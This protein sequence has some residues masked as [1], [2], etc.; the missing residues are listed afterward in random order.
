MGIPLEQIKDPRLR[1]RVEQALRSFEGL[2]GDLK[3]QIPGPPSD[4]PQGVT[5][6]PRPGKRIR[7]ASKP[8]MNKLEE[9]YCREFL[10]DKIHLGYTTIQGV[11]FML[12]RGLWYKPDFVV[13]KPEVKCIEVKGP[14]VFRGGFEN[15]KMAA[16]QYPWIK[17][18]LVWKDPQNGQW[19]EQTVLP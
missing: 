6:P 12:A 13:W 18:I 7:Q 4:Y 17:W 3:R 1:E 15:L 2:K 10:D 11:R 9:E 8:L 14:H 5:K 19:V 16:H